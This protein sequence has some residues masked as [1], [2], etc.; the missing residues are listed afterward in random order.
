MIEDN[1]DIRKCCAKGVCGPISFTGAL[2]TQQLEAIVDFMIAYNTVKGHL[3]YKMATTTSVNCVTL[4][5][6]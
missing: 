1:A 2:L 5:I 3:S 6:F 4:T